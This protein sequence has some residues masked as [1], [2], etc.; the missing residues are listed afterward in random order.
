MQNYFLNRRFFPIFLL[1]SIAVFLVF[2]KII[3]AEDFKNI[4]SEEIIKY[5]QLPSDKV[6]NL[7]HSLINLFNSEW[8]NRIS[9]AYST[10]EESAVPNIMREVAAVQALNHLLI[11]APVNITFGIVKNGVKIAKIFLTQDPSALLEELERESVQRAV[12]YGMKV[13]LQNE[14]RITPGALNF[15]YDLQKGG[16]REVIFQYV[17]IYKPI[18]AKSGK[19]VWSLATESKNQFGVKWEIN[20]LAKRVLGKIKDATQT[21]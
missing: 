7:I 16:T 20:L 1:I 17:M 5:L 13:L 15:K 14:I 6:E 11:D 12:D 4:S 10:P 21:K 3:L 19:L 18:D 8:I 2:P 9:D